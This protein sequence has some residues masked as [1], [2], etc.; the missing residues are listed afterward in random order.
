MCVLQAFKIWGDRCGAILVELAIVFPVLLIL[1]LGVFEF[2]N[3]LWRY[4]QINTGVRD[5]A[6][7]LARLDNPIASA[8]AGK[9]LAVMGQI[10]GT[11]KRVPWWNVG[12]VTV[13]IQTVANADLVTGARLY[14]GPDPIRIV[15]VSTGVNYPGIGFLGV[16]GISSA[17][18]LNL[19]H[20]ERVIGE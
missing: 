8:T 11:A 16:L 12:D 15:R 13:S 7:Y 14:R 10:G 20:E 19:F 9:E 1:G 17:V 6:R 4:H 2:G 5:A 18:T 3:L